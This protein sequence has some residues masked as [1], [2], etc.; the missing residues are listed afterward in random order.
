M[1]ARTISISSLSKSHAMTGWRIGWVAGPQALIQQVANIALC[2]LYGSPSFIQEAAIAAL[3]TEWPQLSAMK[4]AYRQRRDAICAQLRA[5]R[6]AQVFEPQG[7]M[8]V[9][10]DISA[11]GLSSK[12][13]AQQLLDR[14]GVSVL[15][16]EA[17]GPSSASHVRLSLTVDK[18]DLCQAGERIAACINELMAAR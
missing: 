5:I 15:A 17:F 14:H 16:G 18:A 11:T 3:S 2:M 9:M 8:F 1:K 7:G 13:F 4:D 12:E 10:L 6:G